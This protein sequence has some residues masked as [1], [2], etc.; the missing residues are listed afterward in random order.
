MQLIVD[1][2]QQNGWGQITH[3]QELINFSFRFF[4][5]NDVQ[6]KIHYP[7]NIKDLFVQTEAIKSVSSLIYS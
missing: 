4:I 5:L 3:H 6:K 7:Y 2:Q 1:F